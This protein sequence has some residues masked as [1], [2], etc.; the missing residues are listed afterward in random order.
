MRKWQYEN[1]HFIEVDGVIYIEVDDF[2]EEL[3]NLKTLLTGGEN[4]K[5]D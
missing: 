2:Q 1:L 3:E 4:E 5:A